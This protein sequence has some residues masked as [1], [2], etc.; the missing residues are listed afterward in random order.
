M[1]SLPKPHAV[2]LVS[3]VP[4]HDLDADSDDALQDCALWLLE[5]QARG[6]LGEFDDFTTFLAASLRNYMRW[7][8][9][10]VYTH[11][12]RHYG[13]RTVN[14]GQHLPTQDVH[15]DGHEDPTF[16]WNAL[17][18]GASGGSETRAAFYLVAQALG[19]ACKAWKG[20]TWVPWAWVLV[21][22]T[23]AQRKQ[24]AAW[25]GVSSQR[26]GQLL[27]G[28]DGARGRWSFSDHLRN[29]LSK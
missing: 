11:P 9:A 19:R 12:T 27:S 3:R 10:R 25:A 21:H 6:D 24:V 20:P 17:A 18:G 2:K 7:F 23:D 14:G 4:H 29:E 16:A 5:R 15:P 22:C 8:A 13:W 1:G 28:E 26:V